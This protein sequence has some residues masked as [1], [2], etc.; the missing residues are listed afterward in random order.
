MVSADE[1]DAAVDE[2]VGNLLTSGPDA[3]STCKRMVRMVGDQDLDT[4][5]PA[6]ADMI[7]RLRMSEE[8]QEGMAAF[9]ER[10]K[11]AWH[12]KR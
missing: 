6:T 7:A 2:Y 4:A 5:G 8:G 11:P 10:R 12:P 3:L 1:L 9:L